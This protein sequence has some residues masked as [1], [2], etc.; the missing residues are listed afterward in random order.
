MQLQQLFKITPLIW[1]I[2]HIVWWYIFEPPY[3]FVY[4]CFYLFTPPSN[5]V[6]LLSWMKGYLLTYLFTYLSIRLP[7]TGYAW[8]YAELGRL[9][10]GN[11]HC[12]YN[13][14]PVT[15]LCYAKTT[16]QG[17]LLGLLLEW[18]CYFCLTVTLAFVMNL[19]VNHSGAWVIIF[20]SIIRQ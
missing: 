8:N 2:L 14:V 11:N 9:A 10:S 15:F 6:R 18:A 20:A 5:S 19:Q 1:K 4:F 13:D 7:G 12:C 17:M 16:K 3:I